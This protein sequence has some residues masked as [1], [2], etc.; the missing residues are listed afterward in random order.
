LQIIT[1]DLLK[2]DLFNIH[3]SVTIYKAWSSNNR[4]FKR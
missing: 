3:Q 4:Q 2:F 1:Y